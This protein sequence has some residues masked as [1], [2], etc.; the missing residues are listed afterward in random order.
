MITKTIEGDD[1]MKEKIMLSIIGLLLGAVIATGAFY[2]Y[3]KSTSCNTSSTQQ[4]M[5]GDNP[6]SMPSNNNGEPP[7][8]PEGETGEP[9]EKPSNDNNQNNN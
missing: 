3:N 8:K 6:P 9:P 5:Q 2:V 4:M 7:E 1:L